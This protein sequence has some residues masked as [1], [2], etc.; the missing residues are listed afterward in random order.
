MISFFRKLGWLM[1]RRTK[2]DQLAAELQFHLEEEA[3]ERQEAG[4]GAQDARWAARRELG[5]LS[6]VREDTRAMWSWTSLEQ[7][8]QDLRYAARTMLHNPAFTVLA[9][10][11]LALG[12]GANTAIY[13]FMDALLMRSL[14]VADPGSLVVLKWHVTGKQRVGDSVLHD[15]SGQVYDDPRTG[16]TSAV[17]PFPAFEA[18]RKSSNVLSVLFAYRPARKLNVM[19]QGQAEV[20]SG[21]YVSGDYFR[22]LGLAPAAG[23][24][25]IGDDDRP[26]AQGVV[27]LSYGFAQ[28]RFGEAA[29]AVGQQVRINNSSFTAIGVAPPGFFGVDPSKAPDLYLPL[30]ADLLLNPGQDPGP[31][32]RYLDEHYYWNEMTGRLRPGVTMGQAQ[33]ALASVFDGWVAAT[34][35]NASERKNL[36]EFLLQDGAAGLDNLQRA[37]SRPLY[38]LLA[39]VALILALACANIANLLLARA[40]ARRREMAVR[41]GMGAGRWQ[42]I[43]Q[44]LT[45]SLLLALLGGAA[46][47]LFAFWGIKFLTNVLAA[48]SETF[49][50]HAEL[51]FEVLAATSLLTVI[52]GILF[53][54]APALQA[55]RVDAMPVLK[56]ARTGE[57]RSR[58]WLGFSLGRMLVVSQM[59]ICVLLLVAAG[60]FVRTISN[61]HS[62]QMGFQRENILLFKLN[63]RQAGHGDPEI[64]PFYSDLEKRL[65]AIPG[66]LSATMANSPLIGDGAWGW[67][68]VPVGKER[69]EKAPSG[70]GSGIDRTA[71]RVLGSGPGF[72]STMHIPLL[73]GREFD[74]R[75]R[76]GAS[77]VAI[78]NEAWVKANLGGGN[79]VGRRVTSFGLRMKPKEL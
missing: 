66:V 48:G 35:T 56:E 55:T 14:P 5:N 10:L 47:I 13:S 7:L 44:L 4:M 67:P 6:V 38:V 60:L 54:L 52:T 39:M 23:R 27:V 65:A 50:L 18:L 15:I 37:Y 71:T 40:T 36:P 9:A 42:L 69:P 58:A 79:P 1:R 31:T 29:R 70:H 34:A 68:V 22:G 74:E 53:G 72:F 28:S 32:N 77:R 63:A 73:A 8:L 49:T 75:D 25:I 17:F 41:L 45:E 46:G 62:V 43:R 24:L 2:E 20:T 59:V 26:G 33:A 21:E 76:M 11:S 30:H 78:V 3:D 12:I 16:P 61:L 51:N 64:L 57:P 19:I